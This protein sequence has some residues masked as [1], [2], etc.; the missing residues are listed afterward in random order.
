MFIYKMRYTVNLNVYIQNAIH[1]K[2]KYVYIKN[3]IKSKPEYV[4]IQ[5][6]IHSKPKCLYTKCDTQ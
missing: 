5:N 3:A 4:Y 6:A 1:S 2:P